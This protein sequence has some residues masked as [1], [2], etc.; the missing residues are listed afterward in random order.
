[1][2][3]VGSS[4]NSSGSESVRLS[5]EDAGGR[6]CVDMNCRGRWLCVGVGVVFGGGMVVGCGSAVVKSVVGVCVSL[7]AVGCTCVVC[8]WVVVWC[9]GVVVGGGGVLGVG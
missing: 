4:L 5:A 6:P 2:L 8:G 7:W 3:W 9:C 1:M